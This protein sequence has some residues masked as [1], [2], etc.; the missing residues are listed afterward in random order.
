MQQH[1][2]TTSIGRGSLRRTE[3]ARGDSRHPQKHEGQHQC[4][5]NPLLHQ[6]FF[7][8]YS[9]PAKHFNKELGVQA[10]KTIVCPDST[11]E[12]IAGVLTAAPYPDLSTR[13]S[14]TMH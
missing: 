5:T 8:K 11:P 14:D 2:K 10:A 12:T 4:S 6:N 9:L 13:K 7:T 1:T 3:M